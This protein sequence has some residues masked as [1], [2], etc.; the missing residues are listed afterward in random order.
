MPWTRRLE[1]GR[2]T[3]VA[4]PDRVTLGTPV[5]VRGE[6]LRTVAEFA[7]GAGEEVPFVLTWSPSYRPIPAPADAGRTLDEA[8]AGWKAW[9]GSYKAGGERRVVRGGAALADHAQGADPPRDRRHRRRRHHLPAGAARRPAQLGLPLLL[10]A[11]RDDHA[12]RPGE[13]RLPR[14]G[15]RLAGVAAAGGRGPAE[16]DADHVR[17]RR[18]AAADRV[19]GALARGLRGRRTRADR[20]R[21]LGPAAA[22]R[23][24][25]GAGRALPGAAHGPGAE[26]GGLGA[27]AAAGR[28]PGD[29]LG[30][31]G[32]G[33]LGGA[34]R[35]A[36]TSPTPR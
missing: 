17:A 22:R 16:P 31:A 13:L 14:G 12:L 11:R 19:R 25:R 21:R 3:A 35:P 30:A 2:L 8:T 4:G 32:R 33:H 20:Q 5:E 36:A 26:R 18:R 29:G 6:D 28:A 7:V 10:A 9:A 34:R 1:D 24:R 23:L 27:G 15:G